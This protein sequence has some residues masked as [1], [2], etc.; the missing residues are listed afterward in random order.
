[1]TFLTYFDNLIDVSVGKGSLLLVSDLTAELSKLI[2]TR[3]GYYFA[4]GQAVQI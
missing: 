4:L 3:D 1:M 2:K